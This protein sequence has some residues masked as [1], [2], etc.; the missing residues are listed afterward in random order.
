MRESKH[1][2]SKPTPE[3]SQIRVS[4]LSLLM[5]GCVGLPNA[6]LNQIASQFLVGGIR[7]RDQEI[8][9]HAATGLQR[10]MWIHRKGFCPAIGKRSFRT[11][12]PSG[13]HVTARYG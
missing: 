13:R 5:I 7:L 3:Q 10:G 2:T 6:R 4:Q 1:K 11:Y 9:E 8:V 12:F